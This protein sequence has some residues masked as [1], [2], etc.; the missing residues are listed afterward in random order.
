MKPY[1]FKYISIKEIRNQGLDATELNDTQLDLVIKM[2]SSKINLFTGQFFVPVEMTF[3]VD[4]EEDAYINLPRFIPINRVDKIT[5]DRNKTSY[6]NSLFYNNLEDRRVFGSFTSGF[7]ISGDK[8]KVE[9]ITDTNQGSSNLYP[10]N[11]RTTT[12]VFP[13]G[14]Q[15]VKI[16]GMFGWIEDQKNVT[17]TTLVDSVAINDFLEVDTLVNIEE[18]D[19]AII[20]DST[21]EEYRRIW[22]VDSS[23]S[24]VRINIDPISRVIPAST[25]ISVFGKTPLNIMHAAMML[26][27]DYRAGLIPKNPGQK[28]QRAIFRERIDNYEWQADPSS[29]DGLWNKSLTTFASTGNLLVDRLLDEFKE[30]PYFGVV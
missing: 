24:P 30:L 16:E 5:I 8:R 12:P 25:T 21:K 2:V 7:S 13:Q 23:T 9:F 11:Y 26:V 14:S 10:L 17:L 22:G 18:G 15:N 28:I 29:M 19:I 6:N 1:Y 20:K 27:D 3:D 4:G